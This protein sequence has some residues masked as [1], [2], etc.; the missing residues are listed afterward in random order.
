MDKD[1]PASP[2]RDP[3]SGA[4]IRLRGLYPSLKTALQ[5][6]ADV[7]LRQPEMAIYASVNEVAAAC[8]VSEATVMRFC[9]IL[10]FR[11]FQDFK[12]SLARE[13][14]LPVAR[15]H[16]QITDE[17]D[18]VN[19]VR[20]V[21]QAKRAALQDTLEVMEIGG[22]EAACRLL[23]NSRQ[24]L[25][26]GFGGSGTAVAHA[27]ARFLLLGLKARIYSDFHFML[28]AAALLTK[29]DLV[30]AVSN[31][32]TTRETVE[33]VRAARENGAKIIAI[34]N[35]SLSPLSRESDLVLATAGRDTTLPGEADGSLVCQISIIDALFSLMFQARPE[36]SRETLAR[37][38]QVMG[39]PGVMRES[40]K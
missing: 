5:K 39:K 35:N 7:V 19:I 36:Q 6:V 13:L 3:Q 9:R 38:E 2:R 29:D 15:P 22:M 23:L 18:P 31:S 30:L 28:M 34:T 25:V 4:L 33:T 12:I 24:I 37:L 27:G 1:S 10:G 21:F 8:G 14:V 40:P 20:K 32:G 17:D 16:E 11:G 26:I